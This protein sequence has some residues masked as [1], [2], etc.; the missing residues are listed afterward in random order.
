MK[1]LSY[2]I[3]MTSFKYIKAP[4]DEIDEEI[5]LKTKLP[6]FWNDLGIMYLNTFYE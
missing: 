4:K 1:Q 5:K 2:L 6:E 3:S